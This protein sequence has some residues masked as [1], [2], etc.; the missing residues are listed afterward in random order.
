[1]ASL[2]ITE[3]APVQSLTLSV[4]AHHRRQTENYSIRKDKKKKYELNKDDE[5]GKNEEKLDSRS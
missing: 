5:K 4:S 1:M 2:Q 3:L